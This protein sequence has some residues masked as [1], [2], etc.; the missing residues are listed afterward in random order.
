MPQLN[1]KVTMKFHM[2]CVISSQIYDTVSLII[3]VRYNQ[4]TRNM[5]HHHFKRAS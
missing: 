4:K 1:H 3:T 5:C 2:C